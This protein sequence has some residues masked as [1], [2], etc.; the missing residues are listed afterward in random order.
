MTRLK[1]KCNTPRRLTRRCPDTGALASFTLT[2]PIRAQRLP[3]YVEQVPGSDHGR[4]TKLEASVGP[5][6]AGISPAIPDQLLR[7]TGT[8]IN[9]LLRPPGD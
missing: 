5:E 8:T 1:L 3:G 4:V 2:A 6:G 9:R 7:V